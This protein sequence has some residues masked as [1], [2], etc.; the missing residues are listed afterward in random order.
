MMCV[1]S[2]GKAEIGRLNCAMDET[3]KIVQELKVEI[4]R[5]KTSCNDDGPLFAKRENQLTAS[6]PTSI[7]TGE[8]DEEQ[9]PEVLEMDQLEAE[10]ESELQKLPWCATASSGS[11]ER[12]DVFEAS[13]FAVQ[14]FVFDN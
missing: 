11:E 8:R 6:G 10:L 5:K 12:P 2:A 9:R 4:L 7:E 3:A 1:M 14:M 13:S